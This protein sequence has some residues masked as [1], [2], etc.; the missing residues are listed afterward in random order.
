M[1][2]EDKFMNPFPDFIIAGSAKSGTT[3]L[4]LMLDQHP[5]V[6]MSAIKETNY[7]IHAYEPTRDFVEH[8]GH[9]TL[10]D[11]VESDIT[12]TQ[13]KYEAL[14]KDAAKGQLLGEAS[15]WYLLNDQVPQRIKAHNPDAKVIIMLRNPSNV[16]FANFVHQVR[17]RAESLTVDQIDS[18]F[19]PEHYQRDNLHP[20]AS[21]LRLPEYS[22][23][24]P[25]YLEAFDSDSLHIMIYEEFSSNRRQ[26]V[27]ELFEFLGLSNDVAIDVEKRVNISGMPKSNKVQD[28][29]QGSM[30]FKKAVG[31]VVPK[32]PRRKIRSF[33]EAINTGSK[34]RM[35][36]NTRKCFDSLYTKDLEFV[37]SLFNREI[38][39]WRSQ[40]V[41]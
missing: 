6:F 24:L 2:P 25:A 33:I 11:Q 19:D 40:R 37:E 3:A 32:K 10:K 1:T 34:A 18:V 4:H 14:F 28:Y 35:D 41:L 12:D 39:S 16:A 29:I 36:N 30:R 23:H 27:G 13:P 7:F 21:H 5:D 26:V 9:L 22:K 8:R 38:T 17:D 20:F 31:L 15:P